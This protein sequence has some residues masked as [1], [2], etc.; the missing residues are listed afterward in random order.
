LIKLPFSFVNQQLFSDPLIFFFSAFIL[1]FVFPLLFSSPFS[2]STLPLLPSVL[3]SSP[4]FVYFIE[5]SQAYWLFLFSKFH[6]AYLIMKHSMAKLI[7]SVSFTKIFS[8][9]IL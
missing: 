8:Y 9:S 3:F 2:P 5:V 7:F 6:M 1:L 4:L